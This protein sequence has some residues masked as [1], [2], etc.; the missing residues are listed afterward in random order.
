MLSVTDTAKERIEAILKAQGQE[1]WAIRLRV[2]GRGIESFA[3][4]LSSTKPETRQAGDLVVDAGPFEVFVDA[5]SAPYL[6]DVVIDFD[7]ARNGFHIQNPNAV[8]PDETGKAA[9]RVIIEQ[10]NPAIA[11]HGGA[12]LPVDLRDGVLYVRMLGGCQGCGLAQ[13]TLTEGVERAIKEAIPGIREVV[14]VTHHA[15]GTNPYYR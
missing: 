8:W 14:D 2:L 6:E 4:D 9:A 13:I 11:A 7:T 15:A 10:V 5:E 12:V 1:G 3:Y